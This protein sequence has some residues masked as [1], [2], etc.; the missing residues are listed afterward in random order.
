MSI[1]WVS[2]IPPML[3]GRAAPHE[4]WH[5][6]A[7]MFLGARVTQVPR[8]VPS[9][10][11]R[12]GTAEVQIAETVFKDQ[13]ETAA[14]LCGRCPGRRSRS[15]PAPKHRPSHFFSDWDSTVTSAP[16]AAQLDA[17]VTVA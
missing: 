15:S 16:I 12:F 17:H 3:D 1:S 8:S 2:A 11:S 5:A 7:G 9:T 6:G 10:S 13:V 4:R 14:Q